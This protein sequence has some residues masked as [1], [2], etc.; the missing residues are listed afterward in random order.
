VR[1]VAAAPGSLE[2]ALAHVLQ[3]GT[4]AS[5]GLVAVGSV[6]L[7]ASGTSPVSGGPP[8]SLPGIVS[9]LLALR[10]AGFLWLGIIGVLATPAVR[11]LRALLGFWRRGERSMAW[12]ALLV[13]VVIAIGVI[14]GVVSG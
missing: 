2:V 11:V 7:V 4:Y 5:I 12:V 13:L 8:M 10:P 1:G 6:L 3:L 14:V 9:D